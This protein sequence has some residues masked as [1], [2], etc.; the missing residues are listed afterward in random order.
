MARYL[1]NS[2]TKEIHDLH[3]TQLN[4]QIDEIKEEHKILL[5]SIEDVERFIE[6]HGYNG[7]KWCM[8]EYHTD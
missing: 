6:E 3:Y 2:N 4:C 8:F 1:A 7:C 5:E